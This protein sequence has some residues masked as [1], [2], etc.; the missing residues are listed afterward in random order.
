MDLQYFEHPVTNAYTEPEQPD[1]GHE[2][3]GTWLLVQAL[4]AKI[5]FT[6]GAHKHKLSR[7]KFGVAARAWVA[8]A[9]GFDYCDSDD[10]NGLWPATRALR[11]A[12]PDA[13][14]KDTPKIEHPRTAGPPRTT[15][16][17]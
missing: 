3:A 11:K 5:L 13:K 14:A 7:P 4:R 9:G 12:V 10:A 6:E 2:P 15:G 1:P 8:V 16:P 17:T